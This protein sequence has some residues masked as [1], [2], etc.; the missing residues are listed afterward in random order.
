MSAREGLVSVESSTADD[1]AVASGD[2]LW[3]HDTGS[4]PDR[5]RRALVQL[6]RGP[7]LSGQRHPSLWDA[8]VRDEP[9]LRARLADLYLELVVDV[10]HEVAFVRNVDVADLETPRVVRTAALTFLDTAMLLHLRQLLLAEAGSARIIVGLDEVGE[11]LQVYS[12]GTD[13][14]GFS[15]RVN[16]SWSKMRKYG[17]LAAT[18]TEGR[19]EIS[20]V[21]R[22]VFGAEQV[23]AVQ[24]ELDRLRAPLRDDLVDEGVDGADD[25]EDLGAGAGADDEGG[26]G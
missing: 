6:I 9:T 8:V 3:P 20:P 4:L 22:L 5:S 23:R 25:V 17:L 16:A 10:D 19:C 21:L 26:Q 14:S 13:P 1:D 15:K 12:D 24:V 18:S 11:H 2:R 7:Y